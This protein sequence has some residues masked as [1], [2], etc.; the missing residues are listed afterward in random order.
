[1]TRAF[2][3]FV[4]AFVTALA[5]GAAMASAA[6]AETPFKFKSEGTPTGLTGGQ[7]ASSDVFTTDSGAVSC[8][9]VGYT[10]EQIGT[11]VTEVSVSPK[12]SE[13]K[14][15]GFLN[16]P[17]VTNGCTYKFTATTKIAGTFEGKADI[18]C[19]AGKVIEVRSPGCLTTV[20]PQT[21]LEKVTFTNIGAGATRE[22]TVDLNLTG[23]KYEEHRPVF[24]ICKNNTVATTNGTYAGAA[25][26]TGETAA[27]VHRGIF[28]S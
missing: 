3:S 8:G 28:V 1:M 12:Y 14:A 2:H 7:H 10:G 9:Q 22:I 21:G 17:I 23:I 13:C 24:S 11:E 19:P 16:I 6:P 4:L 27:K 25:L 20:G 15:F 5:L 26:V 18:V